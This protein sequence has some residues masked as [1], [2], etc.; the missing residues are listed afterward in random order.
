MVE[1]KQKISISQLQYA[2]AIKIEITYLQFETALKS[3]LCN[4]HGVKGLSTHYFLSTICS[5]LTLLMCT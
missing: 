5:P 2:K 4:E 3:F 1:I